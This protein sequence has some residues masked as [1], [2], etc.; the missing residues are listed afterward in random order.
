MLRDCYAPSTTPAFSSSADVHT[1][2]AICRIG[3]ETDDRVALALALTVRALRMGSVCIDLD[4][5]HAQVHD[6]SEAQLDVT[7]L[8]WPQPRGMAAGSSGQRL[9][10][11]GTRMSHRIG[12]LR[13]AYGFAVSGALLATRRACSAGSCK[14]GS[15]RRRHRSTRIGSPPHCIACFR[16]L[17][18]VDTDRQALAAAVA[19]LTRITVLAG[20][21]GTGKTT[22]VARLVALLND[23]PDVPPRVALAAPTGKAA[24]RLADASPY[25]VRPPE[26]GRPIPARDISASTLHRLL[27]WVPRAGDG[28]V[29]MGTTGLPHDLVVVD[30]MSMVSLTMMARLLDALRPRGRLV[31]VGD[32]TLSS[33][34]T[35]AVLA[36]IA[37]APGKPS[38]ELGGELSA[39]RSSLTTA[40]GPSTAWF[41]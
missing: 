13:L 27:G 34:R 14:D 26:S 23:Q 20:G 7:N 5:V 10:L 9:G 33:S 19:A 36:D 21:P 31:M 1:A 8:P 4:T 35:G 16:G 41:S 12:P 18:G 3:R 11:D 40:T 28:F 24:A 2:S 37:R 30:E 29:T 22:T 25:G 39:L 32:R 38:V 17:V 6:E 15:G